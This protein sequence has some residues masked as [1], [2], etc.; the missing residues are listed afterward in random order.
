MKIAPGHPRPLG[1]VQ[2]ELSTYAL[3][4][5]HLTAVA[6]KAGPHVTSDLAVIYRPRFVG[7]GTD[8]FRIAGL[9]RVGDPPAWVHQE[10]ICKPCQ[11]PADIPGEPTRN[12]RQ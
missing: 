5:A 2:G 12:R 10:W 8:V 11:R 7:I 1:V 4:Q 3:G 9:E 6:L